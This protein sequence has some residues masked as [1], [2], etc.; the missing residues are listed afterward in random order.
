ME[1]LTTDSEI[2]YLRNPFYKVLSKNFSRNS[3]FRYNEKAWIRRLIGKVQ[4]RILK[5][6]LS[7]I[8]SI[9]FFPMLL[10]QH[11]TTYHVYNIKDTN[12]EVSMVTFRADLMT[13]PDFGRLIGKA[14]YRS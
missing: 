10:P 11:L 6:N 4:Y 12:A 2:K 7:V 13:K 8:L 3:S 1:K 9:H 14:H 5:L